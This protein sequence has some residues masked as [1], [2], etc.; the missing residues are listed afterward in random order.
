MSNDR[1]I[2]FVTLQRTVELSL[3]NCNRPYRVHYSSPNCWDYCCQQVFV[4]V[5]SE[6]GSW[7]Y[8]RAKSSWPRL[9]RAVIFW[10]AEAAVYLME[11]LAEVVR[12]R[13][14]WSS[15]CVGTAC[16][17]AASARSKSSTAVLTLHTE[18]YRSKRRLPLTVHHSRLQVIDRHVHAS[19]KAGHGPSSPAPHGPYPTPASPERTCALEW[20]PRCRDSSQASAEYAVYE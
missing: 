9:Y 7:T 5:V 8:T 11:C 10:A 3:T 17:I 4:V 6:S 15:A 1:R 2:W 16:D 18:A 12:D 13:E 14:R 19:G 20:W